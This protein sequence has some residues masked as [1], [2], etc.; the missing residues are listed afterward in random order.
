MSPK[1]PSA[2]EVE[3][4]INQAQGNVRAPIVT[5]EGDHDLLR[6]RQE[7]AQRQG[8]VLAPPSTPR[9]KFDPFLGRIVWPD[10]RDADGNPLPLGSR[11]ES[12]AAY[13]V[14]HATQMSQLAVIIAK[15]LGVTD[16]VDIK[17]VEGAGMFHDLGRTRP[18]QYEDNHAELSARRAEEA[19]RNDPALWSE[20]RVR[21]GVC[22][23]ILQH[24]L[25]AA[26]RPT[27]A[28]LIALWDADC[29]ESVRLAP[30]TREGVSVMNRRL[31][32][33]I[34]KWAREPENQAR[35]RQHRG[36]W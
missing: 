22:H 21:E 13:G 8:R 18:W 31:D 17:I 15:H 2:A 9:D 7:M 26:T 4:I 1:R 10:E 6:R 29:F 34:T 11:N 35:W 14:D 33:C 28:R 16:P 24:S 5:R 30:G 19:M 27:D 32:M 23:L 12:M 36:G 20:D 25:A 3:R